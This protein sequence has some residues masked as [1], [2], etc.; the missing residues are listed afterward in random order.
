MFQGTARKSMKIFKQI[1]HKILKISF[2][3]CQLTY[4]YRNKTHGI[5]Q[6]LDKIYT[7]FRESIHYAR[8][9]A[10]RLCAKSFGLLL[11]EQ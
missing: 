3:T 11:H 2:T 8:F 5:L 7:L 10:E 4:R 6:S 1:F 9:H